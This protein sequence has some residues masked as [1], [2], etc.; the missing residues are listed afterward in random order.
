[1]IR[2]RH[3]SSDVI[4][5]HQHSFVCLQFCMRVHFVCVYILYVRTFCMC[6]HFTSTEKSFGISD[7]HFMRFRE[8]WYQFSAKCCTVTTV[9]DLPL[10]AD[11]RSAGWINPRP[12][13]NMKVHYRLYKSTSQENV[14]RQIR[15][16]HPVP[17]IKCETLAVHC[18][19][20]NTLKTV[21]LNA[22]FLNVT[23][24]DIYIYIYIYIYHSALSGYPWGTPACYAGSAKR[25]LKHR[26]KQ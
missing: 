8:S 10:E 4:S 11:G 2:W 7:F 5:G 1:M 20:R 22:V 17:L 14:W 16:S 26:C 6:V 23:A 19:R 12:L 24:A 9:K 21:L 18:D 15:L 13:W 3:M 25:C